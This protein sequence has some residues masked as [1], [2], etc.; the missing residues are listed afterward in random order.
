MVLLYRVDVSSLPRVHKKSICD[1]AWSCNR[2]V[3]EYLRYSYGIIYQD[4][5]IVHGVILVHQTDDGHHID[6]IF[7]RPQRQNKGIASEMLELLKDQVRH[8][9]INVVLP[10]TE[11]L[12]FLSSFFQRRGY[13]IQTDP[14]I[15]VLDVK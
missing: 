3:Q 10:L 13:V 2:P 5:G 7:V 4:R 15:L 8:G 12:S 9:N 11:N 6:H 14:T 1:L